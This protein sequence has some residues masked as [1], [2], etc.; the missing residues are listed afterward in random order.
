[1]SLCPIP[2]EGKGSL[3]LIAHCFVAGVYFEAELL[4]ADSAAQQATVKRRGQLFSMV[5]QFRNIQNVALKY[6]DGTIAQNFGAPRTNN[7]A[8]LEYI[9]FAQ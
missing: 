5:I 8:S 2:P 9:Q 6:D 3:R 7:P 4:E 1:M